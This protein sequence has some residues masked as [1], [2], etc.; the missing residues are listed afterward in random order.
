M[1]SVSFSGSIIKGS[2]DLYASSN[3]LVNAPNGAYVKIGK[4]EIFYQVESFRTLQL[5]KKFESHG[6]FIT[7]RG[8]Y[9]TQIVEGDSAK[10]Y[11]SEKEAVSIGEI[12]DGGSKRTFGEIFTIQGGHL[13]SSNDNLS[14]SP[15]K[16]KVTAINKKGA[17]QESLIY[18]AGRYLTPPENPITAIDEAGNVIKIE[19]EFDDAPEAS[20][21]D[22]D[23]TLVRFKNDITKLDMSYA[24][25]KD[26]KSGEMILSKSVLVL[27]REYGGDSI[28][29]TPCQTSADFSPVNKIPLM[30][31]NS[32]APHA[33]YNKAM[34]KIDERLQDLERQI[35]RVKA[36]N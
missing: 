23:F 3:Y 1:E 27:E 12:I 30:P 31:P 32:V 11:F 34:E 16:I 7:I 15:T 4:N 13:S 26:I 25:P 24:F 2:K 20:V 6:N 28:I 35:A 18:E 10:L 8:N 29:N 36:K 5:K 22:R 21:F 14:G 19:L 33:I 9:T 17:I